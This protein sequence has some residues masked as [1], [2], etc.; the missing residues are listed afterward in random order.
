LEAVELERKVTLTV[1]LIH[2]KNHST[3]YSGRLVTRGYYLNVP[4]K[5]VEQLGIKRGE[6]VELTIKRIPWQTAEE[7][8]T[9]ES[10]Q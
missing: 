4:Q 1:P 7:A 5:I 2:T 10:E 3:K 9:Q 8:Q 6:L